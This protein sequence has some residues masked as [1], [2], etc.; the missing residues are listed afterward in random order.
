[1][2]HIPLECSEPPSAGTRRWP[3]VSIEQRDPA[4][5]AFKGNAPKAISD[6][7][8]AMRVLGRCVVIQLAGGWNL[9]PGSLE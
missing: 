8:W 4:P 9:S 1:M 5:A 2:C 7:Q 6:Q 3:K